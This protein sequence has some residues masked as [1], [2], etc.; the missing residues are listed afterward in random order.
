VRYPAALAVML[1]TFAMASQGSAVFGQEASGQPGASGGEGGT[2]L[3]GGTLVYADFTDFPTCN[4]AA[5]S[6]PTALVNVFDGLAR[7]DASLTLQPELAETWEISDDGLQITFHLRD[8]V[9]WHDGEPFTSDDVKFTWES[10]L[11]TLH[12]RGLVANA[13]IE[14]I[15]TPDPSTVVFNF[16][17]PSPGFLYQIGAPES[18]IIPKHIYEAE[19][20]ETGPH[21]T[22]QELPIGT[23]P[24]KA[25]ELVQGERFVMEAN[26][27]WWGTTAGTH[28]DMG[29]PYLDRIIVTFIPDDNARVNGFESGDIGFL[30]QEALPQQEV[31]RFQQM[32]GRNV[33]FE[34]TGQPVGQLFFFNLRD[35]T[36][37]WANLDV[38]K[39]IAWAIDRE[40]MNE[41]AFFG[42][43]VPSSTT[44]APTDP[45]YN[46]DIETYSPRNVELANQ[47][48]DEA[49]WP[50]G[51]NGIRFQMRSLGYETLADWAEVLKQQLSDVGIDVIVEGGDF[52]PVVDK[53]YVQHDFDTLWGGLGVNDPGVGVS[54]LFRSDNIGD[55]PFNN[56]A[57]YSDPEMDE[58]WATYSSTLDPEA[59]KDA[60][61]R[62]QEKI[63]EDLPVVYVNTPTNWASQNTDQFAG[64]PTDCTQ[65]YALLR[66]V[67]SKDGTPTRQ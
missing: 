34:C 15:E 49:G 50:R 67:W 66:T 19:D 48:L 39:A 63:N 51:D 35:E 24:F 21:A 52:D 62:I 31:A 53:G 5:T 17:Q 26:P 61:F 13:T 58:L 11:M 28:W 33:S 9:T 64:W 18:F 60:I 37:P 8:G 12:P 47:L 27:D 42:I 10:S 55:A 46:P 29:A 40:Q 16:N 56:A 45:N 6:L 38:R 23:G 54:R 25:T 41:R 7:F 59:R 44:F 22:C 4:P 20:P 57:G 14:S 32:P 1:L 36:K 3:Y 65:Q 43:G 2:P 30:Y